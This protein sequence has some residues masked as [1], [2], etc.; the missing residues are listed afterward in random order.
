MAA[1]G[2]AGCSVALGLRALPFIV[3]IFSKVE[4]GI[5]VAGDVDS[6]N[7]TPQSISHSSW[8]TSYNF[9]LYEIIQ[10]SDTGKFIAVNLDTDET[11][12]KDYNPAGIGD[13][14]TWDNKFKGK[15]NGVLFVDKEGTEHGKINSI[16]GTVQK[17]TQMT[18]AAMGEVRI[19]DNL[20]YEKF[21]F[22]PGDSGKKDKNSEVLGLISWEDDITI[23][24][25]APDDLSI[26]G[27]FLTPKGQLW[28]EDWEFGSERKTVTL[29]GGMI[30]NFYGPLGNYDK[31][32][33][34]NGYARRFAW[35]PRFS[36]MAPPHYPV[37]TDYLVTIDQNFNLYPSYQR[38]K[39]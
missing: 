30:G 27:S 11:W 24:K 34:T 5:Y 22:D 23:D 37:V 39:L 15:T 7:F 26:Y 35:D 21:S 3:P 17:D 4:G 14:D 29:Y 20:L 38:L 16:S 8:G 1:S 31:G 25:L 32:D 28:F 18:I 19:T 13:W 6:I 36:G 10:D 2:G 12:V 33:L 9:A